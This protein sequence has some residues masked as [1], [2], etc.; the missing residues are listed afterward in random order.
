MDWIS[1]GVFTLI[2]VLLGLLAASL[3]PYDRNDPWL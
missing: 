2:L 1:A 3:D